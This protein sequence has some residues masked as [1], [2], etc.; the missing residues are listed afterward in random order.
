MAMLDLRPIDL[1]EPAWLAGLP[2]ADVADALAR[3]L[4]AEASARRHGVAAAVLVPEHARA[5]AKRLEDLLMRSPAR[6]TVLRARGEDGFDRVVVRRYGS[7]S[8]SS[9]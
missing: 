3:T 8:I 6:W 9:M 5:V 1:C 7:D 2:A 4:I